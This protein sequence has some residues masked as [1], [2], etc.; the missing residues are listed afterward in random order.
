M[1]HYIRLK[2]RLVNACL[3]EKI[4]VF[5]SKNFGKLVSENCYCSVGNRE[6]VTVKTFLHLTR[7]SLPPPQLLMWLFN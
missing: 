3:S 1:D 6:I 5:L 2:I 7:Q 4:R